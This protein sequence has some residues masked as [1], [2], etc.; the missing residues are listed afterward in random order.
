MLEAIFDSLLREENRIFEELHD[1][2]LHQLYK[3]LI[4]SYQRSEEHGNGISSHTDLILNYLWERLHDGKWLDIHTNY[5]YL[6]GYVTAI[7]G[8]YSWIS[9]KNQNNIQ[10]ITNLFRLLDLGILLGSSHSLDLLQN[11]ITLIQSSCPHN[12]PLIS[13]HS[14]SCT[15]VCTIPSFRP[16]LRRTIPIE[17]CPNLLTFSEKYFISKTP[18]VLRNCISDWPALN[19]WSDLSYINSGKSFYE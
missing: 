16:L 8:Y 14:A 7:H 9:S 1:P 3:H 18:V 13:N 10:Y 17:D 19:L 2:H 4:H 12:L 6:Y 5:R 15:S 11:V